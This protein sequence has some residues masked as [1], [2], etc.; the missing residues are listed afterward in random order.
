MTWRIDWRETNLADWGATRDAVLAGHDP[1]MGEAL[2]SPCDHPDFLAAWL[3]TAPQRFELR[4]LDARHA[5]GQRAV[6]LFGRP[7]GGVSTR[8][9]RNLTALGGRI[10]GLY[11]WTSIAAYNEPTVAPAGPEDAPLRPGFW[12]AVQ[13]S[14]AGSGAADQLSAHHVRRQLGAPEV[15]AKG[16]VL[17]YIDLAP[18]ASAEAFLDAR[19]AS[20]RQS[21]RRKLRRIAREGEVR[22]HVHGPDEVEAA[23]GWIDRIAAGQKARYGD[24]PPIPDRLLEALARRGITSGVANF[25]TLQLD[26]RNVSY[27]VGLTGAARFH[28][29]MCTFETQYAELA[30]GVVHFHQLFDWMIARGIRWFD[31][32]RGHFDY[33]R[34]WTDGAMWRT[35][36]VDLLSPSK[37]SALRRSAA[38]A[39][40]RAR[41]RRA[42]SAINQA[43]APQ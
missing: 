31:M 6:W 39:L 5:S 29:A 42:S 8:I 18:Y 22:L 30:P 7:R 21:I 24:S 35:A 15:G 19:S 12:E 43:V 27:M 41:G 10:P 4:L 36:P 34:D 20:R 17:H 9:Q 3:D 13:A 11:G 16:D 33:K 38:R 28:M 32:G 26:G 14:L 1:A 25:S 2:A 40:L 23:V 37:V